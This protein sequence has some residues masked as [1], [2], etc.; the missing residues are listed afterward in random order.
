MHKDTGRETVTDAT[1][2]SLM[3]ALATA[4]MHEDDENDNDSQT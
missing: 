2:N 3:W 1:D 4:S